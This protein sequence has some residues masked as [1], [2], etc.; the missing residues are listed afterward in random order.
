MTPEYIGTYIHTYLDTYIHTYIR[1]IILLRQNA[2]FHASTFYLKLVTE[3]S[4]IVTRYIPDIV[5]Q[6]LVSVTN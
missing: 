3:T 6:L 2:H 4:L 5:N 1:K